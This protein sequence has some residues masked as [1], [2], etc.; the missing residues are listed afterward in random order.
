MRIYI[1]GRMTGLRDHG[2]ESF[3][4]AQDK[5]EDNGWDVVNPYALGTMGL[6]YGDPYFYPKIMRRDFEQLQICDAIY[7]LHGWEHSPGASCEHAF[8]KM[9][10]KQVFYEVPLPEID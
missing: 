3:K 6:K 8:A 2:K 10:G 4:G 5:L 9:F 7:M 1:A